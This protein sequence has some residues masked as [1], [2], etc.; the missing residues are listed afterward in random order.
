MATFSARAG[1][2]DRGKGEF[3]TYDMST[4]TSIMG[5]DVNLSG[6]V[7]YTYEGQ[8]TVIVGGVEHSANYLSSEGSLK[9]SVVVLGQTLG[10][11]EVSLAG[12]EYELSGTIGVLV[13]NLTSM[14]AVTFGAGLTSF[15]YHLQVQT[16]V[17]TDPPAL[18][19]F[20]PESALLGSQWTQTSAVSSTV[21]DFEDGAVVNTTADST[22]VTY[23]ANVASSQEQLD[24]PAGTFETM[25][26][27]VSDGQGNYELLWWAS[28]ANNLVRHEVH[29]NDSSAPVLTKI[30]TDYGTRSPTSMMLF[31]VVG[32][33]VFVVAVV[34]LVLAFRNRLRRPKTPVAEPGTPYDFEAQSSDVSDG[35][36]IR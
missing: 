32:G 8:S 33:V 21:V 34:A 12:A 22:T 29:K 6:S 16:T 18:G 36:S 35:N 23:T 31:A 20:D 17:T 27:E 4:L 26:V 13:E 19:E 30:L 24:T 7:T 3:W 2:I 11:A 10:S 14:T 15:T 5:F 1:S 9:G 28:D 25:R